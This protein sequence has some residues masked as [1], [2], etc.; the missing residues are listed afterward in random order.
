MTAKTAKRI[1]SA[2]CLWGIFSTFANL[3]S[4]LSLIFADGR[5]PFN[6]GVTIPYNPAYQ[7]FNTIFVACLVYGIY[8]QCVP[9]AGL[10]ILNTVLRTGYIWGTT[11]RLV[12]LPLLISVGLYVWAIKAMLVLR[13]QNGKQDQ[14]IPQQVDAP[15]HYSAGAP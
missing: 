13:S 3:L 7:V 1:I 9:C 12:L 2:A 10:L 15:D 14:E 6:P 8:R 5:V 11:E 4:S